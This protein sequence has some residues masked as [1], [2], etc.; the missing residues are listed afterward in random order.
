MNLGGMN[1]LNDN[2]GG[3]PVQL[4][5]TLS[6]WPFERAL[7]RNQLIRSFSTARSCG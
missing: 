6:N 3:N 7:C 2:S 4:Q 5:L 1:S